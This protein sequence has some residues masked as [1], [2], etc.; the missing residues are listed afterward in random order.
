M[1]SPTC[2]LWVYFFER[3]GRESISGNSDNR[4]GA[5][6]DC[7]SQSALISQH[8]QKPKDTRPC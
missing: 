2:V 7:E 5:Q 6:A 8:G 3:E 1:F 4:R